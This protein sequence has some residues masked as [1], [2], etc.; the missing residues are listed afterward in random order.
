[1]A[2]GSNNKAN[3]SEND[4]EKSTLENLLEK[5]RQSSGEGKAES[6]GAETVNRLA[7]VLQNQ[8]SNVN[9]LNSSWF[10]NF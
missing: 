5:V 10:I 4:N 7:E 9:N 1:M 8:V 6:F 2:N 3:E